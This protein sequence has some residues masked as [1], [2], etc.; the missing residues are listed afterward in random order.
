MPMRVSSCSAARAAWRATREEEGK[1]QAEVEWSRADGA[2]SRASRSS[3]AHSRLRCPTTRASRAYS[4]RL[5]M[6]GEW[7]ARAGGGG[8]EAK[9]IP[10]FFSLSDAWLLLKQNSPSDAVACQLEGSLY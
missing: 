7:N 5:S 6:R 9:A 10:L 2:S 4:L 8:E 1:P 3:T